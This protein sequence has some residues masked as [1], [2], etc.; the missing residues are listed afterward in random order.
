MLKMMPANKTIFGVKI[1]IAIVAFCMVTGFI[2][3]EVEADSGSGN[4]TSE[5]NFTG[6]SSAKTLQNVSECTSE[7]GGASWHIFRTDQTPVSWVNYTRPVIFSSGYD[8]QIGVTKCL[9]QQYYLAYVYDGWDG[10]GN[11]VNNTPVV[12]RGPLNWGSHTSTDS[13]EVHTPQ[14]HWTNATTYEVIMANLYFRNR[15]IISFRRKG[16]LECIR[17]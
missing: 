11:G 3:A 5:M 10:A 13:G 4:E 9:G 16:T 8:Y 2:S 12:Y 17:P 15:E 6:C 7:K 14:Y 1:I